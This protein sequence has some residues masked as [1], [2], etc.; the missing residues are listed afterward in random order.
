MNKR[1]SKT[2]QVCTSKKHFKVFSSTPNPFPEWKKMERKQGKFTLL[3]EDSILSI[4]SERC[5][6][7]DIHLTILVLSSHEVAALKVFSKNCQCSCLS[8]MELHLEILYLIIKQ[9][10]DTKWTWLSISIILIH[11]SLYVVM[12]DLHQQEYCQ[13]HYEISSK[14]FAS[15]VYFIWNWLKSDRSLF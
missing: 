8:V 13:L 4:S 11:K 9:L 14:W 1:T 7:K 15:V 6:S 10:P 3:S 12:P 2:E 5:T